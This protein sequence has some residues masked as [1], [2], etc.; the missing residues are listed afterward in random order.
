MFKKSIAILAV[1]ALAACNSAPED[2]QLETAPAAETTV[3]EQ[4]V[5]V[6]PAP[7]TETIIIDSTTVEPETTPAG[8]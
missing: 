8:N 4:P 6:E 1:A 3:I 2:D 7:A 5:I